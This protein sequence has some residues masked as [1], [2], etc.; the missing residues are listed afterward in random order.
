MNIADGDMTSY[1]FV[2]KERLVAEQH[3][4]AGGLESA[5]ERGR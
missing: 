4:L 3:D 2:S 1:C 5:K